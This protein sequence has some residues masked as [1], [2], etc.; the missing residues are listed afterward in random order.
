LIIHQ[1]ESIPDKGDQIEIDDKL[2]IIEE[3]SDRRIEIVR[4]VYE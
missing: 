1:L 4:I 3:V 2:I